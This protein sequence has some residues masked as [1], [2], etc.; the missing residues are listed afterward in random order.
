[1]Y[2]FIHCYN[3]VKHIPIFSKLGWFELQKIARKAIVVEYKK[4]EIIARQGAPSD[5]FYCLVSGRLQAY[6]EKPDGRKVSADFLPPAV[7]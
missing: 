5:Y 2:S 1:M 4:G 7:R 3:I 6:S